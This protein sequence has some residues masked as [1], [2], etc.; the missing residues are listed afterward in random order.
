MRQ[1]SFFVCVLLVL[2]CS[3]TNAQNLTLKDG[4]SR[5]PFSKM[6]YKERNLPIG[7]TDGCLVNIYDG[8]DAN[9]Y[10]DLQCTEFDSAKNT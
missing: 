9:M 2:L 5:I 8:I 4:L 10:E 3:N 6:P 7:Y 1:I